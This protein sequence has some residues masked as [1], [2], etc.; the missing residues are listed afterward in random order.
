MSG[1]TDEGVRSVCK[2]SVQGIRYTPVPHFVRLPPGGVPE[3]VSFREIP[4][5]GK[6][7][8]LLVKPSFRIPAIAG[9]DSDSFTKSL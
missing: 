7:R 5:E 1:D 3:L 9:V 8:V 6:A 4:S 2:N